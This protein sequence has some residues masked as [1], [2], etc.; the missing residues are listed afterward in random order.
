MENSEDLSHHVSFGDV[1]AACRA[2]LPNV[3]DLIEFRAQRATSSVQGFTSLMVRVFAKVR[4]NDL[5]TSEVKLVVK[6][7]STIDTQREMMG[8]VFE[9][10]ALFF[11]YKKVL[12][13]NPIVYKPNFAYNILNIRWDL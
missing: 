8:T 10:E 12:S 2:I 3:Q 6:L 1:L 7:P 9:R 4:H 5:S 13:S 11:R